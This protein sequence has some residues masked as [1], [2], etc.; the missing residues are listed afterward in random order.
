M[1]EKTTGVVIN[2]KK[3]AFIEFQFMPKRDFNNGNA[4][5]GTMTWFVPIIK[6][7]VNGQEYIFQPRTAYRGLKALDIGKRVELE[8]DSNHPARCRLKI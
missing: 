4:S 5:E 1:R 3:P 8:Y 7:T 2:H 6:Y